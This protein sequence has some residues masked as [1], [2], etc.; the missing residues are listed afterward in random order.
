MGIL[1]R[2][3]ERNYLADAFTRV[4]LQSLFPAAPLFTEERALARV[5]KDGSTRWW[6]ILQDAAC[7][8][9]SG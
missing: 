1:G 5:S 2:S 8:G 7:G 6:A 4:A 3:Y 9:S